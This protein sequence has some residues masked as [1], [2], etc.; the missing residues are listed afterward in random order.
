MIESILLGIIQG[1]TEWLPISSTGHMLLVDEFMG[2]NL[3]PDARELYFIL[4]QLGSVLAVII[5]FFKELWPNSKEKW[6]LWS[7]IA[8]ASIPIMIFGLLIEDYLESIFYNWQTIC[9]ALAFYGFLFILIEH[10]HRNKEYRITTITDINYLDAIKIGLFQVLALIPGTSRSGS[11]II[12]GMLCSANRSTSAKFSF[13]LSIPALAGAGL[14]KTLK[15]GFSGVNS[16]EIKLLVVG[17]FTAFLV[18]I[19]VLRLFIDFIRKHSFTAFGIYRILL[20]AVVFLYFCCF[21]N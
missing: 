13:F 11:T 5:L 3:S 21:N 12:G 15:I 1:I 17:T 20:S 9:I 16:T 8:V 14:L 18:S 7:K 6:I 4:I 19:L 2:F 10:K